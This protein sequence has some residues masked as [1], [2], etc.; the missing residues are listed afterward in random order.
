MKKKYTLPEERLDVVSECAVEY[1]ARQEN[2]LRVE[3]I[4]D[5]MNM[6]DLNSLPCQFSITQLKKEL[7]CSEKDIREGKV[8]S[9]KELRK[10]HSL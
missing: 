7:E 2:V 5:I 1:V 3:P 9:M 4:R 6:E 10:R 8:Y